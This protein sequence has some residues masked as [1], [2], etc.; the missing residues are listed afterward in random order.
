MN[1]HIVLTIKGLYALYLA[2]IQTEWTMTEGTRERR[3]Q[4]RRNG[5]PDN[6][7]PLVR[8]NSVQYIYIYTK[9]LHTI[10]MPCVL[11][12][13]VPLMLLASLLFLASLPLLTFLLFLAS[14]PLLV[15]SLL[16]C[17]C[18][19]F[20]KVFRASCC[21]W[22]WQWQCRCPCVLKNQPCIIV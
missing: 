14:L 1:P 22:Q 10:T 13:T 12:F 15:Y 7:S 16:C 8:T 9:T 5:H 3:K 6:Q 2:F 18:R 20:W 11:H 4:C 21:C 17:V 19:P